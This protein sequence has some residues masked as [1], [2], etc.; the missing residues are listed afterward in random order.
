MPA[1]VLLQPNPPPD[2][3]NIPDTMLQHSIALDTQDYLPK[4]QLT[5]VKAFTSAANYIAAGQFHPISIQ[6]PDEN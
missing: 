2:P 1:Q 5:S 6:R 3:S 4:D